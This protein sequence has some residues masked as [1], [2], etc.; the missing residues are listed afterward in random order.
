VGDFVATQLKVLLNITGTKSAP[1][2]HI[3]VEG[4]TFRD[5]AYTYMDP[6]GLPSGGDWGL[7]KQGAVTIA[8]TE[9]VTI[10]NCLL[11]RLDGNAI[12][13]GTVRVSLTGFTLV[14]AIE[15]H[16]FAPLEARAGV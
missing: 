10:D 3:A 5:T 6:H 12:F 13:I 4:V 14:D 15:L 8:G 11:T 2:H 1:A 16:A 7:Q 9:A